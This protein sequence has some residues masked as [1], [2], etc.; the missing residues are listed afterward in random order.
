MPHEEHQHPSGLRPLGTEGWNLATKII[1]GFFLTISA[2]VIGYLIVYFWV[3]RDFSNVLN[4][5]VLRNQIIAGQKADDIKEQLKN[6]GYEFGDKD[7][8][9]L[10]QPN[11]TT[12]Y[13]ADALKGYEPEKLKD[14][15]LKREGYYFYNKDGAAYYFSVDKE[16]KVDPDNLIPLI[17]E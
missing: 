12:L 14:V 5:S 3:F 16:N 6:L 11:E 4:L 10:N 15:I 13:R 17:K 8:F 9:Q 2:A 7:F 1:F